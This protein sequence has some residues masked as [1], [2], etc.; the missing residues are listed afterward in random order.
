MIRYCFDFSEGDS[1]EFDLEEDGDTSVEPEGFEPPEWMR[2]VHGRCERCTLPEDSRA[3][4]PAALAFEPVLTAFG[5]RV[6]FE[7]VNL[8]VEL[9]GI[10]LQAE[11]PTQRAV[12]Y[13]AGLRLALS[14]CPVMRRLRPMAHFHLP[15]GQ[16]EH[17][18]FRF[19]GTHLIGQ[20]LRRRQGLE[21]DWEL[22]ELRALTA[23]LHM[24]NQ[25]LAER[26]RTAADKDAA[27]NSVVMLDNL[28]TTV[29]M[30]L[31]EQLEPL[32]PLFEAYLQA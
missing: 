2:L 27:I 15:F 9:H 5:S 8:A 1:L 30:D 13:L 3:T 23:D 4:C 10:T 16:K 11:L 19:L 18:A 24:V 28:A 26:V 12:R 6:S 29:E 32:E 17:T 20:W 31:E 14:A 22:N 25:G 7:K 21:P